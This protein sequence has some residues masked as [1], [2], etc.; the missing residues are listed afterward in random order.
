MVL[1]LEP[2]LETET[3]ELLSIPKPVTEDVLLETEQSFHAEDTVVQ[4]KTTSVLKLMSNAQVFHI[5]DHHSIE[6]VQN[7]LSAET[8][9][10]DMYG[11]EPRMETGDLLLLITSGII[12]MVPQSFVE[13]W[14]T[15]L[16]LEPRQEEM[17]TKKISTLK[18]VTEDVLLATIISF[19]AESTVVQ[20]KETSVLKL[21]LDAQ[22]LHGD[23]TTSELD[24]NS[25]L[26]EK[27][28]LKE[29]LVIIDGDH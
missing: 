14:V 6:P 25:E 7:S 24:L 17:I 8:H 19:N 16:V 29:E 11:E 28:G 3:T 21:M 2:I 23:H 9:T 15:E 20:T 27:D 18:L 4:T 13:T 5:R 12:T 26:P 10:P 1:E 22:V